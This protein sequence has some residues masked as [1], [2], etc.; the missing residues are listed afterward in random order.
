MNVCVLL[1][2]CWE[3]KVV[4][5]VSDCVVVCDVKIDVFEV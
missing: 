3:L 2:Y 5:F 4:Q 1:Y